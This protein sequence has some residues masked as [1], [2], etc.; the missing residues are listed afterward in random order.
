MVC[1]E[2]GTKDR[3]ILDL[4][5]SALKEHPLKCVSR[6][7]EEKEELRKVKKRRATKK[8]IL[9]ENEPKSDPYW[10]RTFFGF[11]P[12]EAAKVYGYCGILSLLI[13]N[14]CLNKLDLMM[15]GMIVEFFRPC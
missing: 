11:A 12:K 10:L 1:L 4:I 15:E 9:N 8:R 6:N 3:K 5:K 7:D 14:V 13:V 2:K